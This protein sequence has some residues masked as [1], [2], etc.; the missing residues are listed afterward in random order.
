MVK[1][2][3]NGQPSDRGVFRDGVARFI[4]VYGVYESSKSKNV[5]YLNG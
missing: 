5:E 2:I 3:R 1:D 4:V